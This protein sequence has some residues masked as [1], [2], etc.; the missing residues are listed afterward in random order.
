MPAHHKSD[1]TACAK[2]TA[3]QKSKQ[4]PFCFNV[5]LYTTSKLQTGINLWL[6][7][8]L[9][10][11]SNRIMYTFTR[12]CTLLWQYYQ[13]THILTKIIYSGVTRSCEVDLNESFVCI[14][15]IM[16]TGDAWLWLPIPTNRHLVEEQKQA[17]ALNMWLKYVLPVPYNYRTYWLVTW[18]NKRI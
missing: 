1:S 17:Y 14:A 5:C 2:I 15:N 16:T 11:P 10:E 6:I 9:H 12:T 3:I 13:F 8:Q 4:S 7:Y 18:C